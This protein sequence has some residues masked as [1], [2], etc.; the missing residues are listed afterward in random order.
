MNEKVCLKC[1]R[2]IS[3]TECEVCKNSKLSSNWQGLVIIIDK[4]SEIAKKIGID[5]PGKYALKVK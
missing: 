2:V 1:K 3:G 5:K 4:D